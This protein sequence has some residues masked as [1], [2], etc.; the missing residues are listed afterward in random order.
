MTPSQWAH[1]NTSYHHFFEQN[2]EARIVNQPPYAEQALTLTILGKNAIVHLDDALDYAAG[3]GTLSNLLVKY[4]DTSIQI[5]DRYVRT[6]DDS[7]RYVDEESLAKYRLVINSAMFEHVL[8]RAGLDAVDNLVADDGV[9]M[10]H[11]LVCETIPRDP[12]WF[13]FAPIVHTAFHTNKSMATLMQQWGYAASIYSPQA[14]SWF[15]F[16]K[17]HPQLKHLE[18]KICEINRETQT[19]SF[20][21]KAGFVDYWKGF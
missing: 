4:F 8:D 20:Q 15:L 17:H 3:Y 18:K 6:N 13:Y 16:K 12:G 7:L 19:K 14:K 11:T 9:L 10:L 1:L 21:Y 5:F 2:T